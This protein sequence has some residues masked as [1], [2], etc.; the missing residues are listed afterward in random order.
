MERIAIDLMVEG[1]HSLPVDS[2][3]DQWEELRMYRS[4][5]TCHR[6]SSGKS[7]SYIA[8]QLRLVKLLD[9]VAEETKAALES[10]QQSAEGEVDQTVRPV[11]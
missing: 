7:E 9:G 4:F 10:P 3:D 11:I 2:P 5:G 8:N 1:V 6:L